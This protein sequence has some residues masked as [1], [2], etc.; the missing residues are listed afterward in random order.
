MKIDLSW[1]LYPVAFPV[2]V[3]V[4]STN[5]EVFCRPCEQILDAL[6]LREGNVYAFVKD[7]AVTRSKA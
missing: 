7:E 3:A 2:I 5:L 1:M 6:A 4:Y